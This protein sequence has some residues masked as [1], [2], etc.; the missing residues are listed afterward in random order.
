MRPLRRKP[1]Q[2]TEAPV[3]YQPAAAGGGLALSAGDRR[4]LRGASGQPRGSP[5]G[6]TEEP[7]ELIALADL[8][9]AAP[10]DPVTRL[11]AR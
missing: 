6:T 11:R 7:A 4:R 10:V 5:A 8:T 3:F 1:K 9:E 2:L